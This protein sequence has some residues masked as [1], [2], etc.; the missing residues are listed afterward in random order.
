MTSG[1]RKLIVW[2]V[3]VFVGAGLL[4]VWAESIPERLKSFPGREFMGKLNLP[5]VAAPKIE[6]PKD[7]IEKKVKELEVIIQKAETK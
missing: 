2:V 5:K 7:E 4:V 3:A 6:I 1:T